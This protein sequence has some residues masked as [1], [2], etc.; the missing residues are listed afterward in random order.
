MYR[1][2]N[3]GGYATFRRI[4]E[5]LGKLAGCIVTFTTEPLSTQLCFCCHHRN[6]KK[7]IGSKKQY[8]CQGCHRMLEVFIYEESQEGENQV[9]ENQVR[10]SQERENQVRESRER[11][12]RDFRCSPDRARSVIVMPQ[13]IFFSEA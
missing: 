8:E 2:A 11:E 3:I 7:Y 9:R 1:S 5:Q 10:E 6:G 4:V 13:P 12:P